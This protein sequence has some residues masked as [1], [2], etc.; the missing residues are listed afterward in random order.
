MALRVLQVVVGVLVTNTLSL[1]A[2]NHGVVY[3]D[4]DDDSLLHIFA[5]KMNYNM[6]TLAIRKN[7]K[8]L[9]LIITNLHTLYD[10]WRILAPLGS[11]DHSIVLWLPIAKDSTSRENITKPMKRLVRRYPLSQVNAFGRW[12]CT[13]NWFSDVGPSPSADEMAISFSY[14]FTSAH[15]RSFPL[16]S[17][18]CHYSDKPWMTPS[19]KQLI[20]DR[21]KAFHSGNV[22]QWRA[23]RSKVQ[24]EIHHRKRTFYNTKVKSLKKEDCRK[25]WK[26]V[27]HMSGGSE[28]SNS[29]FTLERNGQP[30]SQIDL[31]NTLNDFF[32]SV[33]A[34]I[35]QLN[36][37]ELPAFLPALDQ[38]P[39]VQPFEVCQKFLALKP[40]KASGSDNIPPRVLK[41][42]AYELA[43]PVT[44]IFNV[45]LKSG[46]VPSIWKDSNI[47]LVPKIHPPAD[48]GEI[49]PISLTLCIS[50]VLEDFVVKWMISD[51][52]DKIDPRQFGC[53]KG[54]STTYC[55]LDMVHNWL[56]HLDSPGQYL[57]VCFLDFSK[58][59]DR[60]NHNVLINKLIELG[61][62]RSL[63]PWI[64]NF[65][66]NHRQCVRLGELTSNWMPITA[67]VPQGTKLGP[68][69]F[70]VMVND[71]KTHQNV[72]NWK[73]VD[74]I[75]MA[76][77][78]SRDAIPAIQSNLESTAI[79]TN[80]NW[81][82]LNAS[83]CKEMLMCFF[84]KATRNPTPMC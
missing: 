57:R 43:E 84:E 51:I 46:V 53:L 33:S 8:I 38:A 83:K 14:H 62:R 82:K 63:I 71:L 1:S 5:L 32:V 76:E 29:T 74:D 75:S 40:F 25:W 79:W 31:A 41:Q 73:F 72:D 78:L 28:K 64:V 67:G 66:S 48:E 15:D 19:I 61:V 77:A 70:L 11:G 9:D 4:D 3:D 24:S 35:P 13:H 45:S 56:S 47:T 12:L 69:L 34:D 27:N 21:Q 20:R 65:L 60:I 81:M 52:R 59:F 58:A 16:K 42:F 26:I 36:L 7:I 2:T 50:K 39:T 22:Q 18:K 49:R 80:Y 37:D 55:L 17:V 23:L 6:F 10:K 30:L 54:R 44:K 68:I